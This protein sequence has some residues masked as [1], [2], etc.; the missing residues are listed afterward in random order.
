[1]NRTRTLEYSGAPFGRPGDKII[2]SA[3]PSPALIQN[4]DI[5]SPGF[6]R[7]T[8]TAAA[9]VAYLRGADSITAPDMPAGLDVYCGYVAPSTFENMIAVLTAFPGKRYVAITPNNLSAGDCL[10]VE[11]GDADPSG[12]PGFVLANPRPPHTAKPMIYASAGDVQA[13]LNTLSAAGVS[14]ARHFIISA[15]WIG[16]EHVCAPAV[17]GYPQADATQYANAPGYDSDVFAAYVFAPPVPAPLPGI[18]GGLRSTAL[19]TICQLNVAWDAISSAATDP[20]TYGWQIERSADVSQWELE[21]T[22]RTTGTVATIANL[23]PRSKYRW[24]VSGGINWSGWQ[25][26]TTP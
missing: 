19:S 2:S 12:C 26:I 8:A 3:A 23:S 14:R 9:T 21:Q 25:E 5:A 16:I 13:C 15:H 20:V 6:G 18:P 22:G 17:C 24:R 4:L 10:D 11:P 7:L 1:M